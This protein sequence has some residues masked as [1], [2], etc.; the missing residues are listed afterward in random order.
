M[1]P[2]KLA[3][4]GMVLVTI[5]TPPAPAMSQEAWPLCGRDKRV[6][7]IVDGDT[8]WYRRVK[9]RVENIDAPE[10]GNGAQCGRERALADEATHYFQMLMR[11]PKLH[12]EEMGKDRY[13][14]ILA[15]VATSDGD[16]GERM[17]VRGLARAYEGG[18]RNRDYWCQR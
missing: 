4:T 2:A 14:R 1:N 18:Y 17:I 9:Y 10:A 16:I 7:C 11:G 6:T 5:A 12:F 3:I 15:R 8:F 13:G